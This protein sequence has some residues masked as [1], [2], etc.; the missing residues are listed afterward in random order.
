MDS[1]CCGQPLTFIKDESTILNGLPA[2]IQIYK[3]KKCDWLYHFN[4]TALLRV[5]KKNE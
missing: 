5:I 1:L 3:C 4:N 2:L